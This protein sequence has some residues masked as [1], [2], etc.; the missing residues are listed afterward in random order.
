MR[1]SRFGTTSRTGALLAASLVAIAIESAAQEFPSKE[2][3]PRELPWCNGFVFRTKREGVPLYAQPDTT[4]AVI[5]RLALGT[6][7]C[8]V[9]V[10]QDFAILAQA[11]G[12]EPGGTPS[13]SSEAADKPSSQTPTKASD[14]GKPTQGEDAQPFVFARNA[15]LWSPDVVSPTQTQESPSALQRLK[16][17]LEYV[18]SGGVPED[19]LLP[20]RSIIG[21]YTPPEFDAQGSESPLPNPSPD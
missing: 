5:A 16:N 18:Q 4:A 15:D 3:P 14:L 8:R 19:G 1:C 9:G 12:S 2:L 11:P 10:Q 13:P 20:Y 7:V 17:M 21:P 6:R